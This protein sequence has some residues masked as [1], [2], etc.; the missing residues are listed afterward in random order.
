MGLVLTA[1]NIHYISAAI[2]QGVQFNA[3]NSNVFSLMSEIHRAGT[4]TGTA[5]CTH[6]H[7]H[8]RYA[9]K[10]TH[11]HTQSLNVLIMGAI[12]LRR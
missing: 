5:Y 1:I 3:R 2:N 11:T 6:T 10:H 8:V 9:R 12:W 7:R 4:I